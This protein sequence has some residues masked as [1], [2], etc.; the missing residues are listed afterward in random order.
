[1]FQRILVGVDGSLGSEAMLDSVGRLSAATG[2]R[3]VLVHVQETVPGRVGAGSESAESAEDVLEEA[4]ARVSRSGGTV[5]KQLVVAPSI[6]G[7]AWELCQAALGEGADLI[8][9]GSRGHGVWAGAV[10]GSVSQRVAQ[11]ASCP[12]L[13]VP[14]PDGS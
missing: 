14:A 3:L 7:A 10:L 12:V 1:M 2:G 13:I 4:A 5:D 8:V 9:V 6:R 11:F